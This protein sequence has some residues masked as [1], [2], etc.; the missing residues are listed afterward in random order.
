MAVQWLRL[1]L[2]KEVVQVQSLAVEL[3]SH[4]PPSHGMITKV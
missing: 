2:L 4:T 1:H 3:G